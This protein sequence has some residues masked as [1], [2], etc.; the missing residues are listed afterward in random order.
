MLV[1]YSFVNLYEKNIKEGDKSPSERC[2]DFEMNRH[3][4][5]R[6]GL[7]ST[8]RTIKCAPNFVKVTTF[9]HYYSVVKES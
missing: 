1:G 2:K 3:D 5:N 4:H 6:Y 9:R 8:L 7:E